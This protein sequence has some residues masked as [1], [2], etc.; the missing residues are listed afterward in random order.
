MRILLVEDDQDLAEVTAQNLR[1]HG[2]VA[3]TVGLGSAALD[4]IAEGVSFDALVLDLKL[5]DAD[6]LDLLPDLKK[7]APQTPVLALTA[8]DSEEDRILGLERGF[9]DYLTKP[10]SHRELAARLR[11]LCR[12]RG[13]RLG[14][15]LQVGVL[16]IDSESHEVWVRRI[17]VKLTLNEYRILLLLAKSAGRVVTLRELLDSVWDMNAD[18]DKARLLTTISR[19][20]GKLGD[21][22]K[23][24]VETRPGGYLLR[25]QDVQKDS[26]HRR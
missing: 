5:P 3:D 18:S 20:R 26:V 21:R 16:K 25:G 11:V 19:L 24:L 23:T 10:F 9:D 13:Q 22:S 17:P 4:L 8:R 1:Q 7:A 15:K 6:G 12:S 2:F 14:K